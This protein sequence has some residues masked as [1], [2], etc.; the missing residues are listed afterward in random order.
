M[1]MKYSCLKT[2][3]LLARQF[4]F[5]EG[6]SQ[7]KKIKICHKMCILQLILRRVTWTS[8]VKTILQFHLIL[9]NLLKSRIIIL[10]TFKNKYFSPLTREMR[11]LWIIQ[12]LI[13]PWGEI[14]YFC[15]ILQGFKLIRSAIV[16]LLRIII[17]KPKIQLKVI[18][19]I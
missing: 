11:N 5:K 19:M 8:Q 2:S 17:G 13:F 14:A 18:W 12:N 10:W 16:S 4:L 3:V 1:S 9:R 15:I 7:N 6:T